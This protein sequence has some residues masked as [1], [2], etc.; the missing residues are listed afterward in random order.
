MRRN[1]L[2]VKSMLWS[3][4]CLLSWMTLMLG[5]HP[6]PWTCILVS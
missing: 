4:Y 6:W 2:S 1:L 3:A 5:E